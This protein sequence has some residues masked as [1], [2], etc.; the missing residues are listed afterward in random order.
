VFF[1]IFPRQAAPRKRPACKDLAALIRA[2]LPLAGGSSRKNETG[3][4]FLGAQKAAGLGFARCRPVGFLVFCCVKKQSRVG[5]GRGRAGEAPR[6]ARHE[7][8]T[9]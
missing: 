9:P 7:H 6:L 1:R 8:E 4:V 3:F 5:F 2:G